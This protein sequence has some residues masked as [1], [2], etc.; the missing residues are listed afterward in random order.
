VTDFRLQGPLAV[1]GH[2]V[3]HS[4]SPGIHNAA[5]RALGHAPAYEAR[6]V[7]PDALRDAVRR[8]VDE[9]FAGF[10]VTIP[11]KERIL[12]LLDRLDGSARSVGAVNTV[13]IDRSGPVPVLIG[14]NTDVAGFLVPLAEYADRLRGARVL[15]WGAGGA[16]RAVVAGVLRRLDP[17]VVTLVAR[18]PES[19]RALARDL[20]PAGGERIAHSP[21]PAAPSALDAHDL[22]VNATP[23]GMHPDMASTPA[24]HGEGLRSG[25]VVYDLVYRPAVTRLLADAAAA[26]ADTIGGLPMLVAQAAE[27]FRLWTGLEMP[28]DAVRRE[29]TGAIP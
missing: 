9:G 24:P 5:L 2:P 7:P 4:L 18:R 26:G 21:W 17:E 19:V 20:A 22:L 28:V 16:S 29:L 12:P 27:A 11:L 6:D 10:S 13:S 14:H 23:L 1:I 3:A 8:L 15:V 25:Q